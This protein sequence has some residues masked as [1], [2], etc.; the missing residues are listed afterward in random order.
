MNYV[1]KEYLPSHRVDAV[2]IE[3]HW[4]DGD[5]EGVGETIAWLHQNRIR[6]ILVGPIVQYDASLP[7]LLALAISH[8]DPLLPKRH[9]QKFVEPL[10]RQ[11]ALLARDT[12]HVPYISIYD[13]LCSNGACTEY[14]AQGVPLL[15]DYGHL[16]KAGSVLAARR[17]DALGVLRVALKE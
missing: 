11:M 1:L 14:A 8:E 16:T 4:N 12:W 7:R 10:D 6:T 13:L 2:L 15:S 3:A 17:I 5:L 9:L